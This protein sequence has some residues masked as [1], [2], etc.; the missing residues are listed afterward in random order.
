MEHERRGGKREGAGRKKSPALTKITRQINQKH[1]RVNHHSIYL[2]NRVFSSWRK[3]RADG[4]FG[5]DSVFASWLLGLELR[6]RQENELN[7]MEETRTPAKRARHSEDQ[8]GPLTSTPLGKGRDIRDISFISTGSREESHSFI[9]VTGVASKSPLAVNESCK[10]VDDTVIIDHESDNDHD[11]SDSESSTT[12]SEL[13]CD[14]DVEDALNLLNEDLTMAEDDSGDEFEPLGDDKGS[15]SEVDELD[16]TTVLEFTEVSAVPLEGGSLSVQQLSTSHV[17]QSDKSTTDSLSVWTQT[18]FEQISQPFVS[19]HQPEYGPHKRFS[20]KDEQF[21]YKEE[22]GHVKGTKVICSLDLLLQQL[23][24]PCKYPGCIH[25]ATVEY[26]LCGTCAVIR[27]KCPS[28]HKGRFCTSGDANGMLS[29]NL[30]TAAAV[31]T[32]GNNFSKIEKF[33]K[34]LGLKFISASTFQRVQ[35]LYCAPVIDEWWENMREKLWA[36][37]ATED[38][39]VCG[40]GQCDSP[41]FSAKNLCY[42]V[43]EMITGYV[44][45]IEVLDKRHVGLKSSVMEKKALNHCLQRL[46]RVLNVIEVCT[47]ASSSIKKLMTDEFKTLFHSLDVWHKAKSIRKSIQKVASTKGNDKV[48][49]WSNQIIN[50]FWHCC[51]IASKCEDT[52]QAL[53]AMKDKWLSLMH[54]VCNEHEWTTGRC[55]HEEM[56][57]GEEHPP[58]FDRRDHDFEV[59]QKMVLEPSLLDS[60]KYY[61]KFRHTGSLEC[62]NSMSLAYAAKRT[63]YKYTFYKAR[64]QLAAIDWNY[65]LNRTVAVGLKGG[66]A[67]YSR[68]YNQRTK[69]WNTRIIKVDKDYDYI[70]ILMAKVVR[71]RIEDVLH[72]D[73]HVSLSENDPERIAPTIAHT[74]PVSSKELCER[75]Q[76]RFQKKK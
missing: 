10:I 23:A 44:I 63:S 49:K 61:V 4:S 3:I 7:A 27:W 72:I 52:N 20:R 51:S 65:H 75:H 35:K 38:L 37:F 30:Q 21:H 68:K 58:W 64:K 14:S 26:S 39:T 18:A 66:E 6:R 29:N 24:G 50:H 46:H 60:F 62:L 8:E 73:R 48:G 32:S 13:S 54:H 47:D 69:E 71:R 56:E 34:H 2:E 67:R 1:W 16:E 36:Q 17:G 19:K 5:N 43:M 42:Y 74:A 9:D 12:S 40:D 76:T 57:P 22:L 53:E 70:P 59:L 25:V 15:E 31:L 11:I 28:G 55:D 41:G 33:A 45:E